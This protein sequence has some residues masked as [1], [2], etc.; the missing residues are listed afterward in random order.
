MKELQEARKLL[1]VS[2]DQKGIHCA[3]KASNLL[4]GMPCL[5]RA[6]AG[7]RA[8]FSIF[9]LVAKEGGLQGETN[10]VRQYVFAGVEVVCLADSLLLALKGVGKHALTGSLH[11]E[12][13]QVLSMLR[14]IR[15]QDIDPNGVMKELVQE[16]YERYSAPSNVSGGPGESQ[17]AGAKVSQ[18]S[19]T[20]EVEDSAWS[21]WA[22]FVE[23]GTAMPGLGETLNEADFEEHHQMPEQRQ[24]TTERAGPGVA[25][26]TSDPITITADDLNSERPVASS[27]RDGIPTAGSRSKLDGKPT[28]IK[29]PINPSGIKKPDTNAVNNAVKEAVENVQSSL[30]AKFT[31]EAAAKRKQAAEQMMVNID[32]SKGL[33]M[34]FEQDNELLNLANEDSSGGHDLMSKTMALPDSLRNIKKSDKAE[35]WTYQAS[36]RSLFPS[37][38]L[39]C[40]LQSGEE[41]PPR[42]LP[43]RHPPALPR[44]CASYHLCP[45]PEPPSAHP[46]P[47]V[48]FP[49]GTRCLRRHLLC[50]RW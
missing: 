35:K 40:R 37:S 22:A 7:W 21:W 50:T 45:S 38:P 13:Q 24:A 16:L 48:T 32:F 10:L 31:A 25:L 49:C 12:V 41:S 19:T 4:L 47:N 15:W 23:E 3:L 2:P 44:E 26:P 27:S 28:V 33:G 36:F 8:V 14:R 18:L 6:A 46:N 29:P 39:V 17:E 42:H 34:N 43:A 11:Q 9:C 20:D 1:Q 30:N 5:Q